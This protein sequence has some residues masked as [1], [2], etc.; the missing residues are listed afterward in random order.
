LVTRDSRLRI[1]NFDL[2]HGTGTV[3]PRPRLGTPR[4]EAQDASSSR[5]SP[6]SRSSPHARGHLPPGWP[7]GPPGS[8]QI[9]RRSSRR[10]WRWTQVKG[11]Q[12]RKR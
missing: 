5:C 8:A 11:R 4:H 12:P 10:C 2:A 1:A 6:V 3:V 7:V 9:G